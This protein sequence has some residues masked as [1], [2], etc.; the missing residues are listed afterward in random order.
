MHPQRWLVFTSYGCTLGDPRGRLT[1]L[2]C[3]Q[4]LRAV[5]NSRH[6]AQINHSQT[7][8]RGS[9][10]GLH[11]QYSPHAEIKLIT[12]LRGAVLDVAVDIRMGSPTFLQWVGM[13]LNA[14]NSVMILIPEGC[15][16]GF[17]TLSNDAELLYL[18]TAP[19]VPE[20]EGGL[21][22]ADPRLAI[23]WPLPLTDISPRD[24]NHA[25]MSANFAG[26]AV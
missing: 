22:F 6:I 25:F 4:D 23:T 8:Q 10:R 13:E 17:Q 2:F 21:H 7:R 12:C 15:A 16:H 20:S 19:Y 5:L 24:Q 11:F 26:I 3:E 14:E 9:V 18:H 1:R